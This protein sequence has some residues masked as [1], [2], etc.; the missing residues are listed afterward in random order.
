MYVNLL[1]HFSDLK[2]LKLREMSAVAGE[3]STHVDTLLKAP[4]SYDIDQ[5]PTELWLKV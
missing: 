5:L 4:D 3:Q 2:I 1:V